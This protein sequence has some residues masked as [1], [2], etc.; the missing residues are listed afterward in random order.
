MLSPEE[1]IRMRK[2]SPDLLLVLVA[3]VWG[4]SYLSAKHLVAEIGVEPTLA[5]RYGIG[6]LGM[7]VFVLVSRTGRAGTRL[8]LSGALLGCS[9]AGILWLETA[10]VGR[11]SATNAGILISLSLI[12]TPLLEAALL[13]RSLPL[14]FYLA[15]S[16]AVV[17]I[18]LLASGTGGLRMPTSGD[19]LVLGAAILRAAH[20]TATARVLRKNDSVVILVTVQML[21]GA[22]LFAAL[23]AP[24]A[25]SWMPRLTIAGGANAAFLGLGCSVFAFLVQ[26]WAV[27]RTSAARAALLMGTEPLWA[28]LI[29]IVIGAESLGLVQILGAAL[30]V[31]GSLAGSTIERRSRERRAQLRP[32]PLSS[33]APTSESSVGTLSPKMKRSSRAA[34]DRSALP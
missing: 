8:I 33:A 31:T 23:A 10:G 25:A 3:I 7:L 28:A 6:A 14:P 12:L 2:A 20:V 26:A 17:G 11:T 24:S 22:V 1:T 19:L 29:G 15:A 13:K 34:A 16:G 30:I 9:Q 21:I 27:Q 18:A 5:L 4:G 32:E